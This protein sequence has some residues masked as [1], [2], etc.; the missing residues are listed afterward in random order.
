MDSALFFEKDGLSLVDTLDA[1]FLIISS[2]KCGSWRKGAVPC[3]RPPTGFRALKGIACMKI[4]IGS[5]KSVFLHD[6]G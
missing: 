4:P 6:A 3:V 5:P 1:I 2:L